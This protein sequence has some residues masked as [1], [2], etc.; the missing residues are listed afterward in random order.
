MVL[1]Q[2][3]NLSVVQTASGFESP[4]LRH[5]SR[6]GSNPFPSTINVRVPERPKG[7]VCKT[8]KPSVR[9]RSL[10]PVLGCLQ[11]SFGFGSLLS[12]VRIHPVGHSDMSYGSSAVEQ[13]IVHP[14]FT[15]GG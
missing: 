5:Y 15:V 2:I 14:V 9:I 8:V 11:Q 10:T 3:A 7:T 4:S 1:E 13:S 12:V 6:R